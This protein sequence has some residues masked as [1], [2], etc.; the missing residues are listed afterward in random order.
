MQIFVKKPEG[1]TVTL[2]VESDEMISSVKRKL[3]E[4]ERIPSDKQTFIYA[5]KQLHNLCTL[6]DY[7]IL[8]DSTLLLVFL[9]RICVNTNTNTVAVPVDS[10]LHP[11][12]RGDYC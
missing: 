11:P 2:N 1:K 10:T 9:P 3:E 4:K 7:N 6:A 8:K 5:G 12:P